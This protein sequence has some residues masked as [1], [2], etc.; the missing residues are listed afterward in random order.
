MRNHSSIQCMPINLR[1]CHLIFRGCIVACAIVVGGCSSHSKKPSVDVPA[2]SS[3]STGPDT[4]HSGIEVEVPY[5]NDPSLVA[6]AKLV[7]QLGGKVRVYQLPP[8]A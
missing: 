3:P 4:S 7:G 1:A 8:N 6:V 5:D 2:R